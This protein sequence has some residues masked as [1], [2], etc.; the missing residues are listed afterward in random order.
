MIVAGKYE[1]PRCHSFV[2]IH[3]L[4]HRVTCKNCG[5]IKAPIDLRYRTLPYANDPKPYAK[6]K[7]DER[8]T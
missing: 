7:D 6:E 2:E 8:T 4:P 1:C 5:F 3:E